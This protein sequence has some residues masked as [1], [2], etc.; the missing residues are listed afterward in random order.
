MTMKKRARCSSGACQHSVEL[1]QIT[2]EL[3]D[4]KA[5]INRQPPVQHLRP[6]NLVVVIKEDD[7]DVKPN[8]P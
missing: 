4:S 3:A 7:S 5:T 6:A 1:A 2:Q 8:S